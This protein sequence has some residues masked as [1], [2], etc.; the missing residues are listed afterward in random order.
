M[1]FAD[2]LKAIDAANGGRLNDDELDAVITELQRVRNSYRA[3]DSLKSLEETMFD[4][5]EQI[6]ADIETAA[7]IEKRNRQ[8]NLIRE[9]ELMKLASDAASATGDASMGLEAAMVGV[10]SPFSGA[11]QSV[12]ARTNGLLRMFLG[13]MM[14]DLKKAGL[15]P[16]FNTGTYSRDIARELWDLSLE[17]P[18]GQATTNKTA[19]AIAGIVHKYRRAAIERENRAG[20]YIR[21]RQGYVTR[22]SHDAHKMRRAGFDAWAAEVTPKLDWDGMKVAPGERAKFLRSVYDAQVTGVRLAQRPDETGI[23]FAFKGPGNLAKKESSS[24][25]LLFRDAD[26]WFDYNERFG[27]SNLNESL[28]GDFRRSAQATALMDV[29]GTNPEAMF[30]KV[31]TRLMEQHRSDFGQVDRLK[32]RTLDWQLAEITGT[33]NQAQNHTAASIGRGIRAVQSM[34]KL[35]GAVLS[36][37]TDLAAVAAERRYQGRNLGEMWAD[38]FGA[39][40]QG[41]TASADKKAVADMIGSGIDGMLGDFVSRFAAQDDAPGRVSKL[42]SLYFKLNL[43]GPWTDAVK[44]GVGLMMARDL[45]MKAG[46]GWDALDDVT[47]RNLAMYGFDAAKWD[48]ARA[49]TAEIDGKTYVVPDA[50]TRA[51]TLEG[52]K[53]HDEVSEALAAYYAD[54]GDYASPTPG[55]RERA[56]LRFGSQPG[57]PQGEAIRFMMQFKA[58]PV[59]VTQKVLG[60]EIYGHGA[61]TMGDALLRGE[62]DRLGL[63]TFIAAGTVLGYFAMQSKEIAKGR[64]PR[65]WSKETFLAAMAQGGGAGIF[66]DFLFGEANRFGGGLIS[67]MAGPTAGSVEDLSEILFSI[68]DGE[69]PTAKALRFVTGHTPFINLFYT[70]TAL[71]YLVLYHLQEWANPGYLRRMERRVKKDNGQE[72]FLPPSRVAG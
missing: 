11:R 62:G 55:A 12:D 29:F 69:D 3:K 49:S 2:C 9:A 64:E 25:V 57:T 41:F 16:H 13:G 27:R 71:D 36:S 43:L 26:A 51:D 20:A 53:L 72:Y 70:K 5:A 61:R 18:T 1:S 67:T 8:I 32:R 45:G 58:F 65:E 33:V 60:R 4:A 54:R 44:R 30:D 59:T 21:Y 56:I 50:L 23:E 42:M 66:G 37:L 52:R 39:P 6:S 28:S 47:R 68:R 31:R 10:S 17:K 14:A 35:G 38:A 19:K 15:L 48:I 24:R 63:A 22:Q 34:A 40:W 7:K 46:L